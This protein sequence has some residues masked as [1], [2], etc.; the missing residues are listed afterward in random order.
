M[1]FLLA[2]AI[3]AGISVLGSKI[4]FFKREFSLG[5]KNILLTGIEYIAIGLVLRE[6][7]IKILD[8]EESD[9]SKIIF[10][11]VDKFVSF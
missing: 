1:K 6:G 8:S 10:L 7:G 4:T 9:N 5:I 11:P 3:L 2:L